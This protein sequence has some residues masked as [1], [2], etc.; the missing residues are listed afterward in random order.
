MLCQQTP[1]KRWFANVNMTLCCDVT[2]NPYPVTRPP[3]ATALLE[4]RRGA[5][6]QAVTRESSDL[7]SSLTLLHCGFG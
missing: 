6:N 3:Y 7:C 5:S 1:P 2:N 4:F